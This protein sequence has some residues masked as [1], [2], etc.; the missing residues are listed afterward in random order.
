MFPSTL[1][2]DADRRMRG[3]VFAYQFLT[4]GRFMR[5]DRNV[6][7]GVMARDECVDC[8]EFEPCYKL[9][10]GRLALEIAIGKK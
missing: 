8:G 1:H 2:V 3:K 10:L 9:S 7:T 4:P 5:A 6:A